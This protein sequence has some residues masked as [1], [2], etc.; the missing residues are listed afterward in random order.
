MAFSLVFSR[1]GGLKLVRDYVGECR[2]WCLNRG[3]MDEGGGGEC[4]QANICKIKGESNR[5]KIKVGFKVGQSTL[6][7]YCSS[8][9]LLLYGG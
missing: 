4:E 2:I 9:F 7:Y 8:F 6:Y 1:S 3:G 5:A